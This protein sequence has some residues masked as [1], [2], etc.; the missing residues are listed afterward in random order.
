M[1]LMQRYVPPGEDVDLRKAVSKEVKERIM[2]ARHY[3]LLAL[4]AQEQVL[5]RFF[6]KK[7]QQARRAR[8]VI[9]FKFWHQASRNVP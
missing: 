5:P 8:V 7:K 1:G 9:E 6:D 3:G 4:K 2:K